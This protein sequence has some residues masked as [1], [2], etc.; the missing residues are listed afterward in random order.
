M[1]QIENNFFKITNFLG[2][3]KEECVEIF[4]YNRI[5]ESEFSEGVIASVFN[6][7]ISSIPLE[8]EIRIRIN[9]P[10][11]SLFDAVAIYNYL[12]ERRDRIVCVVD[13][14]CGSAA[15]FIACAARKVIMK[16]GS[17]Y[18][19]HKPESGV[20][21]N[22]EVFRQKAAELDKIENE[23]F[24][25]YRVKTGL[26]DDQIREFM[27]VGTAFN[28]YE[29]LKYGFID[30]IDQEE[31]INFYKG[32]I[33]MS[34]VKNEGESKNNV[35]QPIG[36]LN[37]QG[38]TSG[39]V[40]SAS[41][42]VYTLTE[43]EYREYIE[44]RAR[45]EEIERKAKE[46]KRNK[47]SN[48][49]DALIN[50]GVYSAS[51]SSSLAEGA[52]NDEKQFSFLK[53]SFENYKKREDL[54]NK[55]SAVEVLTPGKCTGIE[56]IERYRNEFVRNGEQKR[57]NSLLNSNRDYIREQLITNEV[58]VSTGLKRDYI[59]K[60]TIL[61]DFV[62]VV[63]PLSEVFTCFFKDVPLEGTSKGRIPYYPNDKGTVKDF[64]YRGTNSG[65]DEG[66]QW[67]GDYEVEDIEVALDCHK[68]IDLR[69]T[70]RAILETPFVSLEK[71]LALKGANL[72]YQI[73]L[74]FLNKIKAA[75]Y[76]NVYPE[77][78]AGIALTKW[79]L[80]ALINLKTQA[81]NMQWPL[82]GRSLVLNAA[83]GNELLKG[84]VLQTSEATGGVLLT[85]GTIAELTG[86]KL[87]NAPNL[88][89]NGE[90]MVGFAACAPSL[91]ILNQPVRPDSIIPMEYQIFTDETTG[92]SL[93]YC[94]S[95]NAQYREVNITLDVHFGCR[96]GRA[97]ALIR[98]TKP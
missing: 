23:I 74:H 54:F 22:S 63:F 46:E 53:D 3:E 35:F 4:I 62:K 50:G 67:N 15:T 27:S 70:D 94:R 37:N 21:G 78:G 41:D 12:K 86:F 10:G 36:Q 61:T 28:P 77:G 75:S 34:N 20:F 57:F 58:S 29:A 60:N 24:Q 73:W 7:A 85:K 91:F 93:E 6:E 72:G 5:G 39:N 66:Y 8:Q 49:I 88:P 69:M 96:V 25:I 98:I 81:D 40:S 71:I 51:I 13:G 79:S 45:V 43:A 97:D 95:G 44:N 1:K 42:N 11:G 2:H 92:L 87:F 83:Y 18:F 31:T 32:E 33:N 84:R 14:V 17:I 55:P 26:K 47:I 90:K 48:M 89:D 52:M 9:S 68:Y 38:N 80:D 59:F 76:A 82:G 56:E 16:Q 19:I 64:H 65:T 30:E